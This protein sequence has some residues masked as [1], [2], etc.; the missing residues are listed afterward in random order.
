MKAVRKTLAL[1]MVLVCLM[2]LVACGEKGLVGKWV[3]TTTAVDNIFEF[4]KDGT[5]KMEVEG[6]FSMDFT[7]TSTDDTITLTIM[8]QNVEYGYTIDGDKLTMT[9]NGQKQEFKRN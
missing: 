6:M 3:D 9:I 7:Y 2:S 4:N 1:T 8:G 5:G